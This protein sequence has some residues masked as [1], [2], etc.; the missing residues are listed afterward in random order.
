MQSPPCT[1]KKTDSRQSEQGATPPRSPNETKRQHPPTLTGASHAKQTKRKRKKNKTQKINKHLTASDR[2]STY[3]NSSSD[4][5]FDRCHINDKNNVKQQRKRPS[6]WMGK[7]RNKSTN[8]NTKEDT[9]KK[10]HANKKHRTY[11]SVSSSQLAHRL[12]Q[13][14]HHFHHNKL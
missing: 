12:E 2:S 3:F 14:K 1:T 11:D 13:Q 5:Q 9:E 4:E 10:K 8:R 6:I 7:T